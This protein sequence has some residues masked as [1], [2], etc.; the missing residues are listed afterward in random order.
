VLLHLPLSHGGVLRFPS[1][2]SSLDCRCSGCRAESEFACCCPK[3]PLKVWPQRLAR[4]AL[5]HLAPAQLSSLI[6]HLH[7]TCCSNVSF[8][9]A[10]PQTVGSSGRESSSCGS[11]LSLPYAIVPSQLRCGQHEA[12]LGPSLPQS[13]SKQLD[14][15]NRQATLKAR[16]RGM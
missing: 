10:A 13:G 5:P 2:F 7:V 12:I 9:P 1:H 8:L 6:S 4:E 16:F 11:H 15:R 14:G 3:T